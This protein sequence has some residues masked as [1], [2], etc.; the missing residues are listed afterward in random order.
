VRRRD[1]VAV[2]CRRCQLHRSVCVCALIP[3]LETR[4]RL[5]LIIHRN[6]ERKPT[7]TGRLATL[8][9]PNS[10][11]VRRGHLTGEPS[12]ALGAHTQP[13][14]LFPHED[15]T[16]LGQW[17]TTDRPVTLVVPDGNWRQASKVRKRVPALANVPCV[18][19]PD[20]DISRYRLRA[21]P[22]TDGLATMEAIAR[23]LGVLEG[24]PVERALSHLFRV[25]VDRT[26]W[27]R[28]QLAGDAVHGGLPAGATRQPE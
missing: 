27:I 8:C 18:S 7:N 15:A 24:P 12:L 10:E 9:L 13:L 19:L 14:L 4:T 3:T 1:N 25:M 26:L 16:P 23:A 28:G 2:R 6:E 17:A 21:E 5:V 20:G 11:V 22:R